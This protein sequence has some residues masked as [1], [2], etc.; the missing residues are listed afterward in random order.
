M[1]S[2]ETLAQL[3]QLNQQRLTLVDE[4]SPAP[5]LPI[6]ADETIPA[7]LSADE[8]VSQLPPGDELSNGWGKHWIRHQP[9][10]DI[11]S[12]GDIWLREPLVRLDQCRA[13]PGTRSR[14]LRAMW[15]YLPDQ[16]LFLDLSLHENGY[17][18]FRF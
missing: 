12:H 4:K 14:E 1:F 15:N 11:W 8:D 3:S 9:L 5:A 6:A 2:E 7:P 13:N 16:V 18:I 17:S 10:G